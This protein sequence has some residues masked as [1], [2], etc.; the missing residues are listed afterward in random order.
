MRM[1]VKEMQEAYPC[2]WLGL[3][4]V[5]YKDGQVVSAEVTY[6]DKTKS[7]LGIMSIK[8]MGVRPFFTTPDLAF[9]LGAL[10]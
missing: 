10:G 6:T 5:E 1:T 3:T 9:Q 8:G 2:K 7:E 4:E